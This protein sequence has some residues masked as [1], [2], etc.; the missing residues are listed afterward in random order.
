L[1]FGKG[2]GGADAFLGRA[3]AA[4]AASDEKNKECIVY[5]I[6]RPGSY[7]SDAAGTFRAFPLYRAYE[8]PPRSA[9][10]SEDPS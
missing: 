6:N 2:G 9:L 1:S 8:Y 7:Y 3:A 10:S 4:A 5:I